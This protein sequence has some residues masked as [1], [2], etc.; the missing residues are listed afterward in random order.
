MVS[1]PIFIFVCAPIYTRQWLRQQVGAALVPPVQSAL[2]RL[3]VAV[4]LTLTTFLH[5]VARV[6]LGII[7][8]RNRSNTIKRAK[9]QQRFQGH[10]LS[11]S[12][13]R[14]LYQENI[15]IRSVFHVLQAPSK[16]MAFANIVP[17]KHLI[18]TANAFILLA[19]MVILGVVWR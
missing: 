19:I 13:A 9:I 10:G 3:F 16:L 5:T 6:L 7:A 14:D 11:S 8:I 17:P 2:R 15:P 18:Q 12:I 1:D 4:A